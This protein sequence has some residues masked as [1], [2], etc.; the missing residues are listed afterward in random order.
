M[1]PAP[2]TAYAGNPIRVARA[3]RGWTQTDL[4]V[5]AGVSIAT[6]AFAEAG[7]TAPTVA[8]LQK[9]ARALKVPITELL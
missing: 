1:S 2:L 3:A 7:R 6:V 9:I 5:K 8:T 4:A